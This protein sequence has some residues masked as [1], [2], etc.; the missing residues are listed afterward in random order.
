[1]ISP[2]ASTNSDESHPLIID[3][4]PMEIESDENELVNFRGTEVSEDKENN[5]SSAGEPLTNKDVEREI[6]VAVVAPSPVNKEKSANAKPKRQA[7]GH[8]FKLN[9]LED[10]EVAR[11]C[12]R[13]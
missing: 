2:A 7:H 6:P 12:V 10:A 4:G 1:M 11:L 5:F 8:C 3:E 13:V 9:T